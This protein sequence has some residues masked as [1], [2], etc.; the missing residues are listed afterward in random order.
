MLITAQPNVPDAGEIHLLALEQAY[1]DSLAKQDNTQKQLDKLLNAF[2]QLEKLILVEKIPSISPKIHP[3]DIIPIQATPT[4]WWPPPLALPNEYDGDCSKGQAFLTSCQMYICLCLDSFP[5]EQVKIPWALSYMKSGWAAKWAEWIFQWEEKHGGYSKFLDWEESHKEL[6]RDFC[7]A[8]SNV[9]A[10]NKLESTGYYQKSWSVDDYLDKFVE[11]V[12]EVG[13]T[14][15]KTTIVKFWKG[16]DLQIQNTIT[17]MAYGC[18]SNDSLEAWYEATKNVD[19]TVQL[20]KHLNWLT[21]NQGLFHSALHQFQSGSHLF[22]PAISQWS[23]FWI[24]GSIPH[25]P[26]HHHY[27]PFWIILHHN[28]RSSLDHILRHGQVA[29]TFITIH[30]RYF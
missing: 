27:S 24:L 18:P 8:H 14:D 5:E 25:K 29:L 21:E 15:S 3:F 6:W 19:Q 22:L 30:S 12:A 13:Y 23:L 10:I 11:L 17:T 28:P 1:A 9:V 16:L 20:M 4:R 7:L 26:H 2:Q